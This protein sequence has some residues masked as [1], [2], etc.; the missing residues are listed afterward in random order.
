MDETGK[1]NVQ[2]PQRIVATKGV[3]QVSKMAS[4]ERGKTVTVVFAMNAMGVFT[5]TVLI[6]LRK[7]MVD[8][9]M[10]KAPPEAVGFASPSDGE[11]PNYSLNGWN[12]LS[13]LLI[14]QTKVP[15]LLFLMVTTATRPYLLLSMHAHI[16][17]T[18]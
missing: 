17:F 13:I 9:L 16:G 3:R 14:L 6:F 12:I 8:A 2:R 11:I 4:G 18:Y 10:A 5:P 7:R 1:T 15:T